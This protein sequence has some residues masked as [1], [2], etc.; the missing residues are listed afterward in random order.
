MAFGFITEKLE[1]VKTSALAKNSGWMF[2]GYG[3]KILSQAGYFVL[4]ARALGPS[5]FGAFVGAVA[6]IG[7]VAPFGGLG[8]GNV[9]VQEVSR[10]RS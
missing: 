3:L 10:D 5:Q 8:L 1:R 6:L 7:L 2:L 4:I 9:L